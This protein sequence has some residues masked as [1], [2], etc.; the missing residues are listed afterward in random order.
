MT[1]IAPR[2]FNRLGWNFEDR[3]QPAPQQVEFLKS[4][5]VTTGKLLVVQKPAPSMERRSPYSAIFM[6][7]DS[8]TEVMHILKT[9]TVLLCLSEGYVYH[10]RVFWNV[11]CN[12]QAGLGIAVKPGAVALVSPCTDDSTRTL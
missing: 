4:L 8:R 12:E 9:G 11:V 3:V 7:G 5:G 2:E 1:R 6:E 10:D